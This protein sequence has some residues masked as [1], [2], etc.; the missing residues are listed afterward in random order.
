M[1]IVVGDA[2]P[3]ELDEAKAVIA[4]YCFATRH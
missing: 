1:T 2:D 4:G 3:F